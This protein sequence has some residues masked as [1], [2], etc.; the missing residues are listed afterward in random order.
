MGKTNGT[1]HVIHNPKGGWD[2]K[3]GDGKR[4][5]SHHDLKIDAV[6]AARIISVNQ[7]TELKIHGLN[8]KIQQ[9]DSHGNDP[10]PPKG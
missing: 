5:S 3:R 9:S 6:N 8:G 1:H 7:N 2:V 10:Y 4:A